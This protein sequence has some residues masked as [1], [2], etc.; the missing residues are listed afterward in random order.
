M[1]RFGNI[2]SLCAVL[3]LVIACA[4]FSVSASTT[5]TPSNETYTTES[6]CPHCGKAVSWTPIT[7][8]SSN[9]VTSSGHY[10]VE[11]GTTLTYTGTSSI[12]SGATDVAILVAGNIHFTG[13]GH[14]RL[15]NQ[16]TTTTWLIGGGGTIQGGNAPETHYNPSLVGVYAKG[17]LNIIGNITLQGSETQVITDNR[18]GILNIYSTGIANMYGGT[19][20]AF[21]LDNTLA[22]KH[23]GI[24][25]RS[26][27]TFNMYGGTIN[28]SS[29]KYGG[30]IEI[31]DTTS[32][33]NIHGG[34]INGGT[35][36]AGGAVYVNGG[37]FTM[38]KGTISGGTATNGGT[39]YV[40]SGNFVMNG[41]TIQGGKANIGAA[42]YVTG[43]TGIIRMTGGTVNN[44]T[45]SSQGHVGAVYSKGTFNMSGGE[46]I[47][48]ATG[49]SGIRV[50]T[51]GRAILQG[52]AHIKAR[53]AGRD[54]LDIVSAGS[55][56][57]YL[58]LAG[59]ARISNLDGTQTTANNVYFNKT[60]DYYPILQV[61]NDWT[62]YATIGCAFGNPTYGQ[63]AIG[64]ASSQC[65]TW[66]ATT[67][68][69][70]KGGNMPA[71]GLLFSSD[72]GDYYLCG[73]NGNLILPRAKAVVNGTET[74]HQNNTQAV[75]AA[76]EGNGYAVLYASDT[77]PITLDEG[78][79]AYVD[80][81]GCSATVTGKGTLYGMDSSALSNGTGAAVVTYEGVTVKTVTVSPATSETFVALK[82]GSTVTYHAVA[83]KI[84]SVSLR[85]DSV[86][87]YC[88]AEFV[89]DEAIKEAYLDSFGVAVSLKHMPKAGFATDSTCLY[90]QIP[91]DGMAV[92]K[93]H[94]VIIQNIMRSEADAAT[95][96]SRGEMPIY[97]NAYLK[98]NI[99]GEEITI[100]ATQAAS[101]SLK[102]LLQQV[103]TYW[104]TF[105]QGAKDSLATKIYDPYIRNFEEDTWKLYNLRIHANGGYT[106]EE[107]A[108]LEARRQTVMDYMRESVSTLWRSD[109]TL[110]YGLGNTA[111]DN[112]A[113][114]TIV[115]GRLY[116]G[117]PSVYGNGSQ[118]SFLEYAASQDENGIY[119]TSHDDIAAVASACAPYFGVVPVGNYNF[120][121]PIN[122]STHR[123]LDTAHVTESN[124]EQVMYEAYAMLEPGDAAY[125]QEYPSTRGNHIRMVVKVNVVRNADGTINGTSSTITM[126]EQTRTLINSNKTEK[127][128][129]TG[130]TIYVIGGVDRTYK[131]S[132]LFSEHYIP[133][134][135][136]ELRDPTPP[137]ETWVADTLEEDTI[138][139]LFTGSVTSNR[140]IDAVK[141]T[142]FDESGNTLQEVIGY[143]RR[144]Y[145]K[146]HQMSRFITEKP[147][148]MKGSLDLDALKAGNYRCTVTARLTIDDDYIHTVRDLTFSK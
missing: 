105:S 83:T 79:T 22:N 96:K 81:N 32:S 85:P 102:T 73:E 143:S 103:N 135:V 19:I 101:H 137:E 16:G 54:A 5:V 92:S 40:A 142:I 1:K 77:T 116:K 37:T 25:T 120:N 11:S 98:L 39:L 27:G 111:R 134:T 82:D 136:A 146:N 8:L 130:E 121:S 20:N 44:G 14:M 63:T 115:E 112:G 10:V 52:Q 61:A 106:A 41:G 49:T 53:L 141:I 13:S 38:D 88:S 90:T 75:A 34:T 69:F 68:T 6:N 113:S 46:V 139:N 30:A 3:A 74:W 117:L 9:L 133:V 147:G 87:M 131:F 51:G 28:G 57:A 91:A 80:F 17:T 126:L 18:G 110:T 7:E 99:D 35:T 47:N 86:G 144:S 15:G 55:T 43:D 29:V 94:S 124:G 62:G 140:Y 33:V 97:A 125:H 127:H 42:F 148:S 84:V 21:Q 109:K 23:A 4:V 70:T 118:D 104:D 129:V 107:E 66:D 145:D 26:G 2:L 59:N 31:S 48:N 12:G 128:P 60:T 67:S 36:N 138:E 89:C 78:K 132:T 93:H 58:V 108:I 45:A 64:T 123:I 72:F 95:N 76:S 119:L 50:Q 24:Y 122:L 100:M 65:G 114:F 56:R 71:A